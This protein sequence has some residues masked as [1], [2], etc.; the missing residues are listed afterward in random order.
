VYI[1]AHDQ[2]GHVDVPQIGDGRISGPEDYPPVGANIEAR[3]LGYSGAQR[4]PRLS[5]RAP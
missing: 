2:Y 1:G 4:Q 3:V 5:L